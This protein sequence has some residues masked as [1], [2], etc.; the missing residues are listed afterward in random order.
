[1]THDER[2]QPADATAPQLADDLRECGSLQELRAVR[3]RWTRQLADAPPGDVLELAFSIEPRFVGY[4]LVAHHRS[5]LAAVDRATAER[6]GG[7]LTSWGDVDAIGSLLLGAAWQRGSIT[8]DD[9]L[10]WA[11]SDDRWW[12]RAALVATTV[13]NTR[14]RGGRGDARRTLVVCLELVD[15]RDDM[16][17]KALSWSLRSLA[18]HDPAAVQAF[19]DEHGPRVAARVRREATNKLTTGL[20][21]PRRA[22]PARKQ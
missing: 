20:K 14:S 12:R 9:V 7:A 1:M 6:L 8:D 10:A 15:D 22:P 5:A 21:S 18:P 3:R 19:L 13:L 16:V 17:V 11:R 4:E 2:S